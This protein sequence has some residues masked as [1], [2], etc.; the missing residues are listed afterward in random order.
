M[1]LN[2]RGEDR[3]GSGAAFFREGPEQQTVGALRRNL[4]N[5]PSESTVH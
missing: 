5:S 1:L 2:A 3:T 4:L